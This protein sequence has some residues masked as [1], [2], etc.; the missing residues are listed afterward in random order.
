MD[1]VRALVSLLV[2]PFAD[3]KV[4]FLV[5]ASTMARHAL[6]EHVFSCNL[7]SMTNS[8]PSLQ[9]VPTPSNSVIRLAPIRH[10]GPRFQNLN[11][12]YVYPSCISNPF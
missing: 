8:S 3:A 6:L 11:L 7:V 12:M 9:N 4:I 5:V 2:R 10:R 1:C